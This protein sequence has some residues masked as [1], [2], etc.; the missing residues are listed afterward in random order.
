MLLVVTSLLPP[1]AVVFLLLAPSGA[2]DTEASGSQSCNR[3]FKFKK[4]FFHIFY[5]FLGN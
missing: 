2:A 5:L 1:G 4:Y 3:D